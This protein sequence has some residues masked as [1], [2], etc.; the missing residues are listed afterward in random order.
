V[1]RETAN[2]K[3]KTNRLKSDVFHFAF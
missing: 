3:S 1:K 2:V